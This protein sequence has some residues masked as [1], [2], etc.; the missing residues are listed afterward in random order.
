VKFVA[1]LPLLSVVNDVA[2]IITE[3]VA[4]FNDESV[5]EF[6]AT[7][8][9]IKKNTNTITATIIKILDNSIVTFYININE[10]N[11]TKYILD[12]RIRNYQ[13]IFIT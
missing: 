7:T 9:R 3:L 11:I 1:E 10:N 6:T 2:G 12:E 4:S 13:H 8:Y 5:E